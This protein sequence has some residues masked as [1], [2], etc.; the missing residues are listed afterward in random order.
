MTVVYLDLGNTRLK[1]AVDGVQGVQSIAHG[2]ASFVDELD[3]ALPPRIDHAVLALVGPNDVRAALLEF[4]SQ[5]AKLI[6]VARTVPALGLLR[7]AYAAPERLGV[8]RFLSMLSV[9]DERLPTLLV[10]VGTALTVD[11]LDAAGRNRGGRI[12]P[13]PTLMREALNRKSSALPVAGG[14]W[15]TDAPFADDTIPALASG[16]EGAAVALIE[17]SLQ[18]AR[19]QV[20][21]TRLLL[22]GGGAPALMGYLQE[23]TL[24]NEG[25]VLSG[26]AQYVR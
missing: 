24:L 13:S 23:G 25:T 1:F 19:A 8:D 10:S 18:A 5:R 21:Q 12:A 7:I 4:L 6:T 3:A 16:C 26:L 17:A 20:P 9:V 15:G 2:S 11:W 14:E 22:H